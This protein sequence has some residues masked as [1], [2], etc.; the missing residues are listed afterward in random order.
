MPLRATRSG[1]H[2]LAQ[3]GHK[4]RLIFHVREHYRQNASRQAEGQFKGVDAV[5]I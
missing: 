3:L 2:Q 4:Q 1:V 5:K